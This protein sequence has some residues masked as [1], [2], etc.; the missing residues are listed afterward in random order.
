MLKR[1]Y[2]DWRYWNHLYRTMQHSINNIT[3]SNETLVPYISKPGIAFSFDDSARILDWCKYGIELFGYYDVKATFNVNGVH[4]I[5]GRRDHTQ[6]EIDML[7]ELQSNGH[8]IAHHGYKHRNANK[9]CAEFGMVKW[10]EDEIKK[11]FSW[12]DLQS[13]SKNK[14]KFRKTVSFAYPYFSYS[15][16]MNKEIIPKYYKVARGHLIGG[17]LIDFNSTGVVPSL[18]IDSHLLRKPSNVNK[19]LKFAKTAC[20]NI[21]FTSHSILPE[22]AQW[23][24]FGWEFTENEGRWRTSPRVIQYII[25]EAR[26]LDMEF[27]TTAEIGGVATFIDPHFES[28]VRKKLQI[29]EDKWILIHELMSVKELDIRNQNIKS[30][31]GIQYF[32]NLEK[33]NISQNQITDL[34]LLEKLP[35]LKH[36]KK[37]EYLFDQAVKN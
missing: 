24:E 7:L 17:N 10:I 30:L 20:K 5:E 6:E 36:V 18:C 1:N 35:K 9:Y 3:V 8:E 23:E 12:M 32:I 2:Y 15:E 25:D 29:S 22:E 34:R 16:K 33:L 11:L 26:K 14:E 28:C 37:D 21:I 4:T 27:Y 13:H 31:D 19:I